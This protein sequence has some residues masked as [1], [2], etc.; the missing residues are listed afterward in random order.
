MTV[1]LCHV[2]LG[3]C[4]PLFIPVDRI[5]SLKA[6]LNGG[7]GKGTHSLNRVQGLTDLKTPKIE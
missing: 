3:K 7:P 1:D 2:P 4:P 5:P 6:F